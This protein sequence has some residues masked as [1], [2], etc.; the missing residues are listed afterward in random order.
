MYR[1]T[2]RNSSNQL[3][4]PTNG[5]RR[6]AEPLSE[7]VVFDVLRDER[8]RVVLEVLRDR[9]G[10]VTVHTVS[11]AV[12]SRE[13]ETPVQQLSP[14]RV[15][16][17]WIALGHSHLP[18]LDEANIVDYDRDRNVVE[19][20][21]QADQLDAYL[22]DTEGAGEAEEE[23][24]GETADEDRFRT[25]GSWTKYHVGAVFLGAALVGGHAA[26]VAGLSALSGTA[27]A[28]LVLVA[29]SLVTL[30]QV[31]GESLHRLE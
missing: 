28:L 26:G 25:P 18:K 15:Q 29:V 11:E 13:S 4:E 3:G 9:E 8:R 2:R 1:S 21:P 23:T 19:R 24:A 6:G 27:V 20:R 14:E 10:P 5:H 17:V 31:A 30:V 12:A 22:G 16:Q 7:D